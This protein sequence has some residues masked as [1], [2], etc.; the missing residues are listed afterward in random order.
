[1][2]QRLENCKYCND[3]L[4]NGTTRREFCS[5]KCRVYWNRE[6]VV[7]VTKKRTDKKK[8]SS[9]AS[10]EGKH[11]LWKDGDP[12][13]GSMAFYLKYDCYN[14]SALENKEK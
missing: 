10:T 11:K 6:N 1:M 14:Y 9:A 7:A 5:E 4:V 2:K 12:K 8:K 13:E 3:K